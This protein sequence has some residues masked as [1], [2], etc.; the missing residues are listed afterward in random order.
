MFIPEACWPRSKMVNTLNGQHLDWPRLSTSKKDY[1]IKKIAKS[2]MGKES[3]HTSSEL[4][5]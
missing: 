3:E 5:N 2:V 1:D 4:D